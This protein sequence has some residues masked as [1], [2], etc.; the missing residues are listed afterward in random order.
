MTLKNKMKHPLDIIN[1]RLENGY[2]NDSPYSYT[3]DVATISYLMGYCSETDYFV[4][5][6]RY[7]WYTYTNNYK[8][9]KYNTNIIL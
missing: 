5:K 6:T 4:A 9:R 7:E 8:Q 1:E 3:K 2:Y